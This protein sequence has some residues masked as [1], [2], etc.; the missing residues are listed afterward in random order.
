MLPRM[1]SRDGADKAEPHPPQ[2]NRSSRGASWGA[3]WGFGWA[4]LVAVWAFSTLFLGGDLGKLAD[5][6]SQH[7]RDVATGLWTWPPFALSNTFWRPAHLI[8]VETLQTVL[9]DLDRMN[10]AIS[11]L[12]HG[13]FVVVLYRVL[14]VAGRS[15]R[16]AGA[17]SLLLLVYPASWEVVFWPAALSTGISTTL[18]LI[19][20]WLVCLFAARRI[21]WWVCAILPV[22]AFVACTFNEQPPAGVAALPLLAFATAP[23]LVASFAGLARLVLPAVSA[24][25]G[26]VVYAALYL[27]SATP[28]MRGTAHSLV[29]QED[30]PARLAAFG[31]MVFDRMLLSN[32]GTGA[33]EFGLEQITTRGVVTIGTWGLAFGVAGVLWWQ[34]WMR[35]PGPESDDSVLVSSR[36]LLGTVLFGAVV[37]VAMWAPLALLRSY[38]A[39][40]RTAYAP[41][42]GLAFIVAAVLDFGAARA[43]R[44]GES[45]RVGRVLTGAAVL[46][47]VGTGAVMMVGVQGLLRARWQLD[48]AQAGALRQ[49]MPD[50]PPG[51]VFLPISMRDRPART[52]SERFDNAAIGAFRLSWSALP[53]VQMTYGRSDLAAGNSWH[54]YS[55]EILRADAEGVVVTRALGGAPASET[56][57]GFVLPWERV[58]PFEIDEDGKVRLIDRLVIRQREK[59]D[60]MVTP[61]LVAEAVEEGGTVPHDV[62]FR[63]WAAPGTTAPR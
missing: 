1:P 35:M 17:A 11:A 26:G 25:A 2:K 15:R 55:R 27:S 9:W 48:L 53:L 52:G 54:Q 63:V 36:A 40:S 43:S 14:R 10:H 38:G 59:V 41:A 5:D 60:V 42:V 18:Y 29:S 34:R 46:G 49:M 47:V 21:G 62:V 50:P 12:A 31:G 28:G 19:M 16:G 39:P 58:V 13:I 44:R 32:F 8:L 57:G 56:G 37:V 6:L 61:P 23:R 51:T 33:F 22:L 20:A 45:G 3:S 7:Q 30:L 4:L 24:A